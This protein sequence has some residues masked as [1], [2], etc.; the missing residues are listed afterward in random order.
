MEISKLINDSQIELPIKEDDYMGKI[1]N[2]LEIYKKYQFKE[3]DREYDEDVS[4]IRKTSELA[5][6]KDKLEKQAKKE[7]E[8][9]YPNKD[10]KDIRH[11]IYINFENDEKI[12]QDI[13]ERLEYREEQ[14]KKI[15][16]KIK[17]VLALISI[18]ENFQQRMEILKNYE[19][20][21]EDGKI[22]EW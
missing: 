2:I 17:N 12:Q 13:N 15:D 7:L 18:T 1:N 6:L 11:F 21:D 4:F 9:M 19:I 3:I 22:K 5:N 14:L 10:Y 16:E 8:K 20:I